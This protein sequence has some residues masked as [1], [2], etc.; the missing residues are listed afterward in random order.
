LEPPAGS[1]DRRSL[2]PVG[3]SQLPDEPAAFP[4]AQL[5]GA[6][7]R[8]TAASLARRRSLGGWLPIALAAE[9]LQVVLA[10]R[11]DRS[12]FAFEALGGALD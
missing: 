12:S 8:P 6:T 11:G 7:A 5:A 3:D 9:S 1:W 10:A 4:P 2:R